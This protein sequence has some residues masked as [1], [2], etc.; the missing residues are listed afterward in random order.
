MEKKSANKPLAIKVR[1][2]LVAIL[3]F[4]LSLPYAGFKFAEWYYLERE[5]SEVT[6]TIK[7]AAVIVEA[8]NLAK[9]LEVNRAIS[10]ITERDQC[11]KE[12]F[13]F[14]KHYGLDR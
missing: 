6:Q 9:Q 3:I 10:P 12:D 13:D 7:D 11:K 14:L 1:D 8:D 5:S 2:F 4:I